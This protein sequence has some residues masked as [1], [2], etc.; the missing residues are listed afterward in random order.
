MLDSDLLLLISSPLL[1][2]SLDTQVTFMTPGVLLRK[3]A[4][5]S[6]LSGYSHVV[7]DEVHERDRNTDFLLI[8]LRDL[9][10]SRPELRV[11]L[12]SATLQV[13]P[14]H[15]ALDSMSIICHTCTPPCPDHHDGTALPVL[16]ACSPRSW[17][18]TSAAAR[19]R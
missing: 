12:M 3:L 18:C 1:P 15:I 17:P 6:T 8:V 9:L 13:S 16:P 11:I 4:S 2:P 5:D 14:R 7:I 10:P 19:W